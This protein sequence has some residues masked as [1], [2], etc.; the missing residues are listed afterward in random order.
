MP[1]VVFTTG[2]I[3]AVA[4]PI[5]VIDEPTTGLDWADTVRMMTLIRRLHARG[6][7]VLMITH[8]MEIVADYAQRVILMNKGAVLLQA[9]PS[10]IFAHPEALEQCHL[11]APPVARLAHRL[12]NMGVP[13]T[14][15]T[16]D[17]MVAVFAPA[18]G[19]HV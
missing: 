3:L 12:D 19:R 15:A 7:T 2:S 11:V 1:I 4:P 18:E 13:P 16:V 6:H 10:D 17:Q 8:N 9:T 5:I 14:I